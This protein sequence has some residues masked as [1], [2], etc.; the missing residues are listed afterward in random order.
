MKGTST[1]KQG[2]RTNQSCPPHPNTGQ[3]VTPLL[4]NSVPSFH[5]S[6]HEK[7]KRTYIVCIF[8]L[9]SC[10]IVRVVNYCVMSSVF[11]DLTL[12]I[13]EQQRSA[14][15]STMQVSH[16]EHCRNLLRRQV[17]PPS[18]EEEDVFA[19]V[20]RFSPYV[21]WYKEQIPRGHQSNFKQGSIKV[22]MS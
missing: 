18:V 5:C 10:C 20:I 14:Y 3:L 4:K 2:R 8:S 7:G 6:V 22:S 15:W 16:K 12:A 13:K 11:S 19:S 17:L 9:K 1:I 21:N